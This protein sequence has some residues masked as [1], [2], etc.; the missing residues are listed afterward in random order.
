MSRMHQ[1]APKADETLYP[2]MQLSWN[3]ALGLPI[4]SPLPIA[5]SKR[6]Y[7]I[8]TTHFGRPGY[9][10]TIL[11]PQFWPSPE[12]KDRAMQ[13]VGHIPTP[14]QS[15]SPKL[16]LQMLNASARSFN[17]HPS[18]LLLMGFGE[19]QDQVMNLVRRLPIVAPSYKDITATER[20]FGTNLVRELCQ[21]RTDQSFPTLV[22]EEPVLWDELGDIPDKAAQFVEDVQLPEGEYVADD[23]FGDEVR[24][25]LLYSEWPFS[26]D[27]TH[28]LRLTLACR[29]A[30]RMRYKGHTRLTMSAESV[31]DL[32]MA[33]GIPAT[34]FLRYARVDFLRRKIAMMTED[35]VAKLV[36]LVAMAAPARDQSQMQRTVFLNQIRQAA[37]DY[38]HTVAVN[39]RDAMVVN[40]IR[41]TD[42][43]GAML[44]EIGWASE[45]LTRELRDFDELWS[46]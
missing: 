46:D 1:L 26:P 39:E 6:G 8:L 16:A 23:T 4:P 31:F 2:Y 34:S 3:K 45:Q 22:A 19:V 10:P 17:I 20:K 5:S 28:N 33:S 11:P 12:A 38:N 30:L 35:E 44:P 7:N 42:H 9:P 36:E 40:A 27:V 32:S 15:I 24:A 29:V 14:L 37:E 13:P 43:I 41:R 21:R 18:S 25:T